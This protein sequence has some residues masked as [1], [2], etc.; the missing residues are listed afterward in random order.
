MGPAAGARLLCTSVGA[1]SATC[2]TASG[3]TQGGALHE[4]WQNASPGAEQQGS[5][6]PG[7]GGAMAYDAY[8]G[9]VVFFGG[10]NG[11]APLAQTWL[12]S[13]GAWINETPKLRVSPPAESWPAMDFDGAY[14][15][16]LLYGGCSVSACPNDLTWYYTGATGWTNLT[17]QLSE[18]PPALLGASLAYAADEFDF[19]SVL[20]GGCRTVSCTEL[21]NLT[22]AFAGSQWVLVP[23]TRAPPATWSQSL[24]YD[25]ALGKLVLFGGCT[26]TTCADDQ[27]WTFWNLDWTNETATFA[28]SDPT[29]PGRSSAVVT[30]DELDQELVVFGGNGSAGP[31]NDTWELTCGAGSC[32]WT[33]VTNRAQSPPPLIDGLAPSDGNATVGT[34]LYG[35]EIFRGGSGHLSN[36]TYVYEPTL[37]A[38]PR[39]GPTAPAR[40]NVLAEADPSGG[41]G[42]YA[43]FA[44]DYTAVWT[45]EGTETSGINVTLNFSEPGN[46]SVGLT[47][48][49]R[50]G[51]SVSAELT[52]F[53]TGPI[54][55]I[56]GGT[57][58]FVDRPLGLS[59]AAATGGHSPYSYRWSFGDGGTAGGSSVT[60]AW[61]AEGAY[62]VTLYV[63]DATGVVTTTAETVHVMVAPAVNI[64][65]NHPVADATESVEFFPLTTGLGPPVTYAWAF[66]DGSPA[67][68]V[69]S[70]V[71]AFALAGSYNV[72][73]RVSNSTGANA[74][75]WSV[76]TVYLALAGSVSVASPTGSV[77]AAE[78]FVA[79][80]T[81]GTPPYTYAWVFGDGATGSGP[82]VAHR[83]AASGNYT[84][85]VWLNDSVGG[86]FNTTASVTI[87]SAFAGPG[88]GGSSPLLLEAAALGAALIAV[89][90]LVALA[91]R[92][93]GRPGAPVRYD[94]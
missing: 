91:W 31:L 38:T 48:F 69:A 94:R 21:S 88:S 32:G 15:E 67:T 84:A 16:V 57:S 14:D 42:A 86:S 58:A 19:V 43:E 79:A 77:G 72:S 28:G 35:G 83:Y 93:R 90:A 2:S 12:F 50:L 13:E 51:V 27:T 3:A 46:Q 37:S 60:H 66:D 62:L 10:E 11:G 45:Y 81:G 18:A 59:A 40:S 54:S 7:F 76:V 24:T 80:P 52:Y 64:T 55:A 41:S 1:T 34:L 65:V 33:N 20:F 87:T 82:S 78:T 4:G 56:L 63:V 26:R 74:M 68:S 92:R 29:P 8:D 47:V 71:H 75:N 70:P 23:T 85:R 53:A 17:A 22:F 89:G 44:G 61:S 25:P 36:V 6:A 30:W 39:L 9:Y 5:P 73:L 49:D